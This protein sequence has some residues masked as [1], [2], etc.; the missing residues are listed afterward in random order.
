MRKQVQL[1]A[2]SGKLGP[3][4]GSDPSKVRPLVFDGWDRSRT[5]SPRRAGAAVWTRP[6]VPA[7]PAARRAAISSGSTSRSTATDI[8][9][10]AFDAE[11]CGAASAAGSAVVELVAGRPFLAAARVGAREIAAALGGL[12]PGK[13]HA[14]TLAADAL[15]RALGQ[16]VRSGPGRTGATGAR[17][18][19]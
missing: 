5:I 10:A 8:G 9:R 13:F 15:H 11:G 3:S 2:G 6:T 18:S 4:K 12:S 17:S 1:P 14:A 7:P 19:R 16:A